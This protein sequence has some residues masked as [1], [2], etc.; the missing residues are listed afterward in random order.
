MKKILPKMTSDEDAENILEQD[1]SD[2]LNEDNLK[3][4]LSI[5]EFLKSY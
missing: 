1:L 3:T 2:Y 5:Y 4:K